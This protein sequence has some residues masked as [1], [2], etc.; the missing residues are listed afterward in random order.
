MRVFLLKKPAAALR[1]GITHP[2]FWIVLLC[3]VLRLAFVFSDAPTPVQF[4]ARIYVSCALAL[5]LAATHPA[6]LVDEGARED[7]SY[8]LVYADFLRGEMVDWLYY[9]PPSFSDALEYVYFAGPVYPAVL[10]VLFLPDWGHDFAVARAANA[11]FDTVSC[12]LLFWILLM[13]AG[14]LVALVGS[15]L[16]A[17]YPGMIIKCGELNLEPLSAAL[18]LLVVALCISGI[19]RRRPR[20]FFAAG[21]VSALILLTK[22][23]LSLF[24]IFIGLALI[25]ILWRDW[26]L[27]KSAL[28]RLAAGFALLTL[29]WVLLVWI[30][31]GTPGVRDPSYGA[32]NFRSSNTLPD[33][34][35]D[36][37][38][39]R[40]DF[41]TYP[42]LREM[43]A[44]PAE[45]FK[46][47]VEKFYR[48][49]NRSYNDYRIPLLIGVDAQIWFHRLLV[50]VAVFGLFY[51]PERSSR[52]AALLAVA[53]IV[54]ISV[55]HTIWHSLTRYALPVMPLVLGSAAVGVIALAR[56]VRKS[57]LSF[58]G[59]GVF[60]LF[61]AAAYLSWE[62]L[63]AAR[64]LSWWS[65]IS[66]E[67]ANTITVAMRSV[68]L[69]AGGFLI[70][71]FMGWSRRTVWLLAAIIVAGQAILWVR[72]MPRERWAEWSTR[73]W[74]PSEAV[75]RVIH[76]PPGYDWGK[77]QQFFVL[78][79]VQSGGGEQFTLQM[80]LDTTEISFPGGTYSREFYP[81]A[82][83]RPF[84]D[85]YGK[86]R[87]EVRHWV[88]FALTKEK[89]AEVVADNKLIVR[90]SVVAGDEER[91]YLR[92]FGEYRPDKWRNWMGPTVFNPSVE[93]L[94]EEGDPRI[95]EH[96]PRE[97]I[98]AENTL[99]GE[100]RLGPNDLSAEPGLQTGDFRILVLGMLGPRHYVY[101]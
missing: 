100:E 81:K 5:S 52:S 95:W 73:I 46:L 47:Y 62:W 42:I 2:I 94:Y 88:T 49:W 39:A 80:K 14:R 65:S 57:G 87:E 29:P 85:A 30:H 41:W 21:V 83:Y 90:L 13:T 35:Y 75:E 40:E 56:R 84:L 9:D 32:A 15:L 44:Q 68:V 91:N 99:V 34:G 3:L 36:L 11:I 50:M 78:L 101:F 4:D 6:I 79:D 8:D 26:P 16:C 18:V 97:L 64:L 92:V 66:P 27:L 69:A 37:D 51:W 20:R 28:A 58:L 55:I 22:A 12:A 98:A 53:A 76:F 31:Y 43:A 45:Y 54:Y 96:I 77:V 25:V 89:V 71:R 1:V 7:I 67:T 63:N 19:T 59:V 74:R 10:G 70:C 24:V 72:A 17:V 38:D 61:A 23:S 82:A 93:R 60:G 33:R 86:K 48:L